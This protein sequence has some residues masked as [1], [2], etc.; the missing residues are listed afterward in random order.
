MSEGRVSRRKYIAVAGAAAAAAVIG[1]AAYYLTRPAPP[2]PTP[3]PTPKPT[4]TPKP[5]GTPTPTI[6]PKPTATPT[7]TPKPTPSPERP[8]EL[9]DWNAPVS[10]SERLMNKGDVGPIPAEWKERWPFL[11]GEAMLDGY[12]L[13]EGWEKA[14]EGVKKL[15]ITN[16]G[17]LSHDP[18]A[19]INA[20]IF[21]KLTGIK[22]EFV[23][24]PG[25]YTATK[26]VSVCVAQDPSVHVFYVN[27]VPYE[28]LHYVKAGWLQ[29]IDELWPE[30][31]QKFYSPVLLE[32]GCAG[33]DGHWYGIS[34]HIMPNWIYYRPSIIKAAGLTK[35]DVDTWVE[36][37]EV[38]KELSNPPDRWG[39]VFPTRV[40]MTFLIWLMPLYSMGGRVS[41]DGKMT[42]DTPEFR[43][44]WKMWIDFVKENVASPA[45]LEYDDVAAA[46]AFAMGK[47]VFGIAHSV[48]MVKFNDPEWSKIAGDFDV[49]LPRW[50][51]NSPIATSLDHNVYV[52]NKFAEPHHKAAAMLWLDFYRSWTGMYNELVHEGNDVFLPKLYVDPEVKPKIP[53]AEQKSL[54]AEKAV[55]ELYPPFA[56]DAIW[57]VIEYFGKVATGKMA[58]EEAITEIMNEW[59]LMGVA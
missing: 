17:G 31:V 48:Y 3:T 57:L 39:I 12:I 41:T 28:I 6:T 4:A 38:A 44:A 42:I 34:Q 45:V 50:D 20:E 59:K 24:L 22:I 58:M 52:I 21:E 51:E 8:W 14:V 55:S 19:V 56:S 13:P 16:A 36:I 23:E 25:E 11:K 27:D 47:S 18:A 7:A 10:M 37:R 5:T 43:E 49:I 26:I 33:P 30:E 40:P 54:L 32:K 35:E 9:I 2:A 53:F 1:G 15:V 29:P 46:E